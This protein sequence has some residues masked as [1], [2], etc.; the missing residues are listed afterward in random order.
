MHGA[1]KTDRSCVA[2]HN[3]RPQS[4]QAASS[5]LIEVSM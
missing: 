3:I 2:R 5:H 1:V 4:L